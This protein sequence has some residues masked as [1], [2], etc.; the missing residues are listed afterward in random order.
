MA[1]AAI[2]LI[3]IGLVGAAL[4]ERLRAAGHAVV[5][6]DIDPA[7]GAV[8]AAL[9][10]EVAADASEVARRCRRVIAA[11]VEPSTTESVIASIESE[12]R[13]GDIVID[14]GT[15]DPQ[16][17]AAIAGRLSERGVELIDAPLSGSSEQ[18]R[19]GE[20]VAMLGGDAAAIAACSALWPVIARAH[21]HL[22]PTGYG[23]RAK[24][25]TNLI[26]GLNRAALAEGLAF[27]EALGLDP[28]A[29]VELVRVSP[30]YSRAVDAK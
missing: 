15:G 2:G 28:A 17:I 10:G 14:A 11:L 21:V 8:L 20:A 4:A 24:L 3:G 6:Y 23:Q 5:G 30:A 13:T 12:L 22:G 26:L 9:G 27:A 1:D 16:R 18:I 7:R 19:R 25:A 29:F